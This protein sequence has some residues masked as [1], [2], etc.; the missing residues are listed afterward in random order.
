MGRRNQMEATLGIEPRYRALQALASTIR[1][2]R[3]LHL[4]PEADGHSI[5]SMSLLDASKLVAD[6]IDN[7]F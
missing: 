1:P 4:S 2:R 7:R 3:H 6:A 5:G